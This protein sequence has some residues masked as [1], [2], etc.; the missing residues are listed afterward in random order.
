MARNHSEERFTRHLPVKFT[1]DQLRSKAEEL[2]SKYSRVVRMEDEKKSV[3]AGYKS[4]IDVLLAEINL[5]ATHVSEKCE[6]QNIGCRAF[7]DSPHYGEKTIYR[8]DTGEIVGTEAMTNEDRQMVLKFER[9]TDPKQANP[10]AVPEP[11]GAAENAVGPE[12]TPEAE[13]EAQGPSS[14]EAEGVEHDAGGQSHEGGT[15][16]DELGGE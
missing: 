9:D 14:D 13:P 6:Y 1:E 15:L 3:A 5:L 10:L 4:R 2:A 7:F 11:V 16:L 12:P 8:C